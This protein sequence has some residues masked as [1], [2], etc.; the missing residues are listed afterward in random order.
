MNR[1][2]AEIET[3]RIESESLSESGAGAGQRSKKW[4]GG[5]GKIEAGA[6]IS[7]IKGGWNMDADIYKD[8]Y[9]YKKSQQGRSEGKC[10]KSD[11]NETA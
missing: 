6:N 4:D 10:R 5:K 11:R 1:G 8:K 3:R 9:R 7:L 2:K